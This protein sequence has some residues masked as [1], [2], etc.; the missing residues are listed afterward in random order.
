MKERCKI[1]DSILKINYKTFK[2][3][4][5][6]VP[7]LYRNRKLKVYDSSIKLY[8]YRYSVN[9]DGLKRESV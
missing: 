7:R 9:N 2:C 4:N 1:C 3:I 8:V 5:I 6:Y